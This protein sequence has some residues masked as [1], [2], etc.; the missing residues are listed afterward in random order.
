[1]RIG[2]HNEENIKQGI[3]NRFYGSLEPLKNL[4]KLEELDISNTDIN[5]GVEFLPDSITEIYYLAEARP[6]NKLKEM[7]EELN[8]WSNI[9]HSFT[10]RIKKE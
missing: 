8:W 2:T 7:E 3:H 5:Q 4:T 1:L 9:D 10:P 6:E